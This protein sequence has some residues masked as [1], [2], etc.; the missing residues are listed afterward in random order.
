MPN[1]DC[2]KYLELSQDTKLTRSLSNASSF[3]GV[4]SSQLRTGCHFS[5]NWSHNAHL[6]FLS[7]NHS[8]INPLC[9]KS[10]IHSVPIWNQSYCIS[11]QHILTGKTVPVANSLT[12][13]VLGPPPLSWWY[14]GCIKSGLQGTRT[15]VAHRT[16]KANAGVEKGEDKGQG[17][18]GK[19]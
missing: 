18:L 3:G 11:M 2:F 8:K 5:I 19:E 14:P 10:Q 12:Q 7:I 17:E 6:T 1:R 4:S 13:L 16:K 9:L 15:S